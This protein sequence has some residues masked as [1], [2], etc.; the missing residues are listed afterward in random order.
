MKKLAISALGALFLVGTAAPGLGATEQKV[1]KLR[2]KQERIARNAASPGKKR[3][4]YKQMNRRI[5]GLL[6]RIERGEQV[7]ASEIDALLRRHP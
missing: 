5:D 7:D 4:L 2:D 6:E 1:Q 3:V